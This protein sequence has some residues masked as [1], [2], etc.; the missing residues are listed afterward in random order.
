MIKGPKLRLKAIWERK[1]RWPLRE[2]NR[3][4]KVDLFVLLLYRSR[5]KAFADKH[6]GTDTTYGPEVMPITVFKLGIEDDKED[7]E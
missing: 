7:E 6:P 4:I 2:L 1:S 5:Y 3:T